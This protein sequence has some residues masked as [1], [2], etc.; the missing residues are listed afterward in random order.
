MAMNVNETNFNGWHSLIF[1]VY[2]GYLDVIDFLLYESNVDLNWKDNF[3]KS[4]LT[5]AKEELDDK[6]I[7]NLLEEEISEDSQDSSLLKSLDDD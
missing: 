7:I 3:N 6:D 1:A 5:I 2:G 4:A